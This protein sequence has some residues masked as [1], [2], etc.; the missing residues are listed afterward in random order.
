MKDKLPKPTKEEIEKTKMMLLEKYDVVLPEESLLKI[1]ALLKEFGLHVAINDKKIPKSIFDEIKAII[2][3][4]R[5][6]PYD[7]LVEEKIEKLFEL[8]Y[9]A[10]LTESQIGQS[11]QFLTRTLWFEEGLD[12]SFGKCIDDLLIL[13]SKQ[14]QGKGTNGIKSH[15]KIRKGMDITMGKLNIPSSGWERFCKEKE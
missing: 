12:E 13:V 14:K 7:P 11:V 2:I 10:S 6:I 5:P 15:D 8:Q 3:E 1:T 9:G 4:H